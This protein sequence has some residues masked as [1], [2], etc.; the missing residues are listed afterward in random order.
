MKYDYETKGNLK[1]SQEL[2]EKY[3]KMILIKLSS[4]V[5][6]LV[7]ASTF[8]F[9]DIVHKQKLVSASDIFVYHLRRPSICTSRVF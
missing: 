7:S 5:Y 3:N 6:G 9:Y 8:P 2:S 4:H 1:T